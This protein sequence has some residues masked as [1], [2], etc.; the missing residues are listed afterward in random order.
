M[1]AIFGFVAAAGESG[2]DVADMAAVA[3][4]NERR[5]PHAFGFAWVDAAGRLRMY[6]QAGRI[7]DHMGVLAMARGARAFVG[8]VRYATHGEPAENINNH[9]HP[10]DGGWLVHNGVVQNYDEL[11]TTE[12]LWPV[13][14]CD[15]EVIGLLAERGRGGFLQRMADAAGRTTGRLCV[16]ALQARP[17]RLVVVKRGNPLHWSR[18]SRGVFMATLA[19]RLPGEAVSIRDGWATELRVKEEKIVARHVK[20]PGEAIEAAGDVCGTYRGG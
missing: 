10:V 7:S 6:K 4:V 14:A 5:G 19:D 9:P 3:K 2:L 17:M 8:H 15:S 16:L 20:V 12:R 1:C 11:V 18:T 13:S